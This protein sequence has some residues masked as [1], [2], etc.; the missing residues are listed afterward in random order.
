MTR[1]LERGVSKY[2]IL[3][4]YSG[5]EFRPALLPP[6]YRRVKRP[7]GSTEKIQQVQ[8]R[9]DGQLPKIWPDNY[10]KT[11]N[12]NFARFVTTYNYVQLMD[13]DLAARVRTG[14]LVDSARQ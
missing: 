10:V 7:R 5:T 12:V 13:T 8:S 6:D 3:R 2:L 11:C 4:L 1:G 14:P 9:C